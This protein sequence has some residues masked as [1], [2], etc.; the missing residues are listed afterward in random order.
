MEGGVT[1]RYCMQLI[2]GKAPSYTA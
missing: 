1:D 2:V